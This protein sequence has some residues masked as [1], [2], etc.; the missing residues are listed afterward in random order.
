MKKKSENVT[1]SVDRAAIGSSDTVQPK[2]VQNV[3]HVAEDNP[4]GGGRHGVERHV[5]VL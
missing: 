5:A 2:T 4:R 3:E 1:F